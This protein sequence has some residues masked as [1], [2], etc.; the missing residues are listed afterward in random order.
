MQKKH[1]DMIDVTIYGNLVLDLV[2]DQFNSRRTLGGIA[3]VWSAVEQID[4]NVLVE[5]MPVCI[6][7]ALVYV[8]SHTGLKISKP[9]LQKKVQKPLTIQSKV[10]H[11]AYLNQIPDLSF[12]QDIN[13]DIITADLAGSGL[14]DYTTL[15][16]IDYLFVAEDEL[17]NFSRILD[18]I[19][20][21]V[22]VHSSCGSST[23][24]KAGKVV[25]SHKHDVVKSVNVLGAGDF[26]AAAFI[27]GKLNNKSDE[28]A[29]T[30][31]HKQTL[32]FL[33]NNE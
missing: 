25:Y 28:Q 30:V 18:N 16:Y 29:I 26:F 20:G 2:F 8:N 5:L 9:N 31:A 10:S 17:T 15:Q 23:Y 6:G 7:S 21:C 13:S 1:F 27:V 19:K 12:I 4:E 32:K 22:I 14:F 33:T 24:N 11:I 3:N